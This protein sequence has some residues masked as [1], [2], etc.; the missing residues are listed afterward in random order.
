MA[1]SAQARQQRA[2]QGTVGIGTIVTSTERH[3]GIGASLLHQ[4]IHCF[5]PSVVQGQVRHH[6]CRHFLVGEADAADRS[7]A[8]G[9]GV[10]D[11]ARHVIVGKFLRGNAQRRYVSPE[12]PAEHRT[13]DLPLFDMLALWPG[14]GAEREDF[15]RLIGRGIRQ[16]VGE[17][18]HDRVVRPQAAI[19][20]NLLRTLRAARRVDSSER[21]IDWR[22]A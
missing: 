16:C 2:D 8:V 13:V 21:T 5:G 17:S 22:G 4:T 15:N 12:T 9:H 3:L 19:G 20:E 7:P 18:D 14:A 1:C 10:R 11:E 6:A